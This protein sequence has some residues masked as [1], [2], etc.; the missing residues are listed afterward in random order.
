MGN[1]SSVLDCASN[2]LHPLPSEEIADA[3]LAPPEPCTLE[4]DIPLRAS[5]L[6]AL[7]ES[8][9][10]RAG[11]RAWAD[12]VVPY[13]VTSNSFI[14]RAYAKIIVGVLRD[15]A[16]KQGEE[17]RRAGGVGGAT[18]GGGP[19]IT[20]PAP[21][22]ILEVGAGHGKLA[23]LIV[24]Y[25]LQFKAFLPSLEGGASSSSS[26]SSSS[27][28]AASSDL[29]PPPPPF[30]YIITDKSQSACEAIRGHPAL[31]PWIDQGIVDVAVWDAEGPPA[32]GAGE[33]A[34][35]GAALQ[36]LPLLS[37]NVLTRESIGSMPLVVVANYA[38]NSMRM[39]AFRIRPA[40]SA[41]SSAT[42]PSSPLAATV[43]EARVTLISPREEVDTADPDILRRVQVAWTYEPVRVPG[44]EGPS[45]PSSSSSS[46]S[47]SSAAPAPLAPIYQASPFLLGLLAGYTQSACLRASGGATVVIPLG[48]L[49]MLQSL[50]PL[51]AEGGL[52]ALV[53]DKGS[54][55]VEELAALGPNADPHIAQHGSISMMVNFHALKEYARA[56][57]GYAVSTPNVDGFK[58]TALFFGGAAARSASASASAS[59]SLATLPTPFLPVV[60]RASGAGA[61]DGA[62]PL[63]EVIINALTKAARV[64]EAAASA[65]A[66]SSSSSSSAAAAAAAGFFAPSAAVLAMAPAGC[67]LSRHPLTDFT[68]ATA[69]A[70]AAAAAASANVSS[71]P[72]AAFSNPGFAAAAASAAAASAAGAVGQ[73]PTPS[74]LLHPAR[75]DAP[76]DADPLVDFGG[77]P[78][79][80]ARAAALEVLHGFGPED[81][82]GLQRSLREE[83]PSSSQ[84]SPSLRL[85][86]ALLRLAQH[87]SDVFLK[88]KATLIDKLAAHNCPDSTRR[89]AR[90]DVERIYA[91]YFSLQPTKDVCFEVG[92]VCMALR[93]YPAALAFFNKSNET[94]GHHHVTWHNM[95]VCYFYAGEVSPAAACFRHA[96]ELQPHYSEARLWLEKAVASERRVA[97]AGGV[98]GGLGADFDGEGGGDGGEGE[99]SRGSAAVA[100]AD[101]VLVNV[102]GSRGARRVAQPDLEEEEDEEDED[103][104]NQPDGGISDEGSDDEEDEGEEDDGVDAGEVEEREGRG[105]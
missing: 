68:A 85:C 95:G 26:S 96:L 17:R 70:A 30:R 11:P 29:P 10:A 5:H 91:G 56:N 47:S 45:G 19:S 49:A 75:F 54:L 97:V 59:P 102:R 94:C 4:A 40:E 99:G 14:A 6:W 83:I 57:N 87:D 63:Q 18:A 27:G 36:S 66:S 23:F 86:L 78:F 100:A 2:P 39:D 37:G 46:S 89:D 72:D 80:S 7:Q 42:S 48:G 61:T 34:G 55:S 1:A 31:R 21:L 9:Y 51:C 52:V 16:R 93:D 69:A 12:G 58:A 79:F 71:A 76:S 92:R 15:V 84:S 53:G 8:F 88:F 44:V 82:A 60:P 13:F 38:L 62:D 28:A 74:S 90:F 65:A 101:D 3:L 73:S 32:A 35:T 103:D 77:L 81:F 33:G 22:T 104:D 20:V 98:G 41:S 43:E 25:L 50:Q 105:R 67:S 24:A 64:E